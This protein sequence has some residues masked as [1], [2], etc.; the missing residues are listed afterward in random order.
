VQHQFC[1]LSVHRATTMLVYAED[2]EVP[3]AFLWVHFYNNAQ[4]M[5]CCDFFLSN[6]RHWHNLRFLHKADVEWKHRVK[7]FHQ[8]D[9]LLVSSNETIIFLYFWQRRTFLYFDC[10]L[11]STYDLWVRLAEHPDGALPNRPIYVS[12]GNSANSLSRLPV[13]L[14]PLITVHVSRFCIQPTAYQVIT[15]LYFSLNNT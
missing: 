3:H 9:S 6:I 11:I 8:L 5:K 4:F 10:R 14:Q 12:K 2:I 13:W 1:L 15:T 7:S